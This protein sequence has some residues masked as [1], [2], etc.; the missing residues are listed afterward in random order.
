MR[1]GR[2]RDEE[3]KRRDRE[4]SRKSE[5]RGTSSER[6]FGESWLATVF[7]NRGFRP[8]R[9]SWKRCWL[10]TARAT[11]KSW[12]QRTWPRCLYRPC[13]CWIRVGALQRFGGET[14]RRWPSRETIL[15]D[16]PISGK[17][18]GTED[19][20]VKRSW[21][22]NQSVGKRLEQKNLILNGVQGWAYLYL[23]ISSAEY[24]KRNQHVCV[25][26][27]SVRRRFSNAAS[28]LNGFI[29]ET[30]SSWLTGLDLLIFELVV[31][32]LWSMN[33]FIVSYDYVEDSWSAR[34]IYRQN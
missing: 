27:F 33:I 19:F 34:T 1:P 21:G 28:W 6:S 5:A 24:I 31:R 30:G 10:N 9:L 3:R 8:G 13:L 16:E 12:R 23:N 32:E 7:G 14:S 4:G 25:E 17:I 20:E 29:A 22:M 11:A 15:S 26:S 2:P 18:F